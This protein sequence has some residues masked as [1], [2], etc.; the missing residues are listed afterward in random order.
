MVNYIDRYKKRV[1]RSGNNTGEAYANNTIAFIDSSFD[2]SPTF[3][4]LKVNSTE[5][6]DVKE[7]DARVIDV[8][9]MGSLRE[10]LFRPKQYLNVGSYVEFDGKTWIISDMWGDK[11]FLARAL[12]QRCNDKLR[13]PL[14]ENWKDAN[15]LLDDSKIYETYCIS[16]QS[17]LG[18]KATQGRH[19]IGF[20]Q[21]DVMLPQGQLFIYVEK[22]EMTETVKLNDR[23][24]FGS[25]VYEVYGIDDV[26]LVNENGYGILQLTVKLT[27]KQEKDDFKNLIAFNKI[28]QESNQGGSIW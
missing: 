26:S 12:V 18:S 24:I 2:A 17:P 8:E 20:N 28:E 5:F 15:D 27:T 11:N 19:D 13:I 14:S 4:V 16:S 6:P 1:S 25:N 9:R 10:I 22:N 3:H 23:F 7:I 21:Y